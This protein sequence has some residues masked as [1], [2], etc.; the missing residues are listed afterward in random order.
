MLTQPGYLSF[1]DVS[2][3]VS[4]TQVYQSRYAD[5]LAA[6]PSP[7]SGPCGTSP[8]CWCWPG[9]A[10]AGRAF[11]RTRGGYVFALSTAGLGFVVYMAY[12]SLVP[13]QDRLPDVR[14]HL[15]RR[16]RA[17]HV[18]GTRTSY[19][20]TTIPRRLWQDARAALASPAALTLL[21]VFVV[22]GHGAVA[23]FPRR[24]RSRGGRARPGCRRRPPERVHPFLGVPAARADP[25]L[26]RRRGRGR[27]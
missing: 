23:F 1:C 2:A 12:A 6:C 13:A 16:G 17:F 8:C 14:G 5:A 20:M 7:C 18:S 11:A 10:G 4:C 9:R 27:S 22:G 19:P 26:G 24:R 3:T 15:R 25:G 21:L